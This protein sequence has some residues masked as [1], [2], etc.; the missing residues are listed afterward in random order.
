MKIYSPRNSKLSTIG[1]MSHFLEGIHSNIFR[2]I[3]RLRR[4]HFIVVAIK[5]TVNPILLI[6]TSL[7]FIS[8][9][10]GHGYGF[11]ELCWV[12]CKN[13]VVDYLF[14]LS[15]KSYR[16]DHIFLGAIAPVP[17]P[18]IPFVIALISGL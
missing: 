2:Y 18:P 8:N 5:I 1:F 6:V 12:H 9:G 14:F 11:H 15:S 7:R 10:Q 4:I 17:L 3:C 13:F 16:K